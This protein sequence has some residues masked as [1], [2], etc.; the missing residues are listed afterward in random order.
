MIGCAINSVP[1]TKWN[2]F[3]ALMALCLCTAGTLM[4]QPTTTNVT[5][6]VNQAIPDGN[7]SGLANTQTLNFGSIPNFSYISDLTVTLN[8]SGGFNGDYYAYLVNNTG[9]FAV[10]LN[11]VGKTASNPVGYSDAG[12]SITLSDSSPNNIHTYQ[13]VS[14]PGGGL[15]TG[16]WAPDGRNVDPTLVVDSSPISSTLSSFI[17]TNP[18][19]TWTLFLAD[20]DYGEQGTLQ[21]WTLTVTA[22][23]EPS[24]IALAF[25]GLGLCFGMRR[26]AR[27]RA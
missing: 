24:S 16:T 26:W 18:N 13:N 6:T 17:G 2:R 12:F 9:G 25:L 8:V 7:P 10:L 21:N 1:Y 3:I 19:G 22:V 11:R 14:N 27:R 15:L 5:F 4:A 23:P 20:L